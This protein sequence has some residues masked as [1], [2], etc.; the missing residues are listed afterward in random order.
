[1]ERIYRALLGLYPYDFRLWFGTDMV[2]AFGRSAADVRTQGAAVYLY[3]AIRELAS[4]VAGCA[5][6]WFA[7]WTGDREARARSLPDWRMMRPVGIPKEVWFGIARN[8][9]SSDI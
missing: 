1:M 5:A 2:D 9:C 8:R 3:L 4:L 6:E 7:K